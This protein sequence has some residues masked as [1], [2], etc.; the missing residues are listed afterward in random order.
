MPRQLAARLLKPHHERIAQA[1]ARQIRRTV[2]RYEQVEPVALE[3]NLKTVLGGIQRLLEK[4]DAATL[5]R[6]VEDVAQL[7]SSTGFQASEFLVAGMCFLPVVRRFLIGSASTPGEGLAAY[8]AVESISLPLF[9][10]LVDLFLD[11]EEETT[12]PTGLRLPTTREGFLLPL[13]IES[14]LEEDEVTPFR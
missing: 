3:R 14:V 2:P 9:G 1:V 4:G 5:L 11:A 8:E 6:V 7:R 12:A 13:T 10:Q